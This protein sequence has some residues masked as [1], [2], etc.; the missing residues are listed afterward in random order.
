[1]RCEGQEPGIM[2]ITSAGISAVKDAMAARKGLSILVDAVSHSASIP[3]GG[4][5]SKAGPVAGVGS[6]RGGKLSPLQQRREEE[7]LRAAGA[8]G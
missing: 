3:Q 6:V 1:M 2:A 4:S 8:G 7:R 5:I